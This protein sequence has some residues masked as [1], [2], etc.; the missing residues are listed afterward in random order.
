M[1]A[2]TLVRS[3]FGNGQLSLDTFVGINLFSED[4]AIGIRAERF[5]CFVEFRAFAAIDQG[6]RSRRGKEHDIRIG[7]D[8]SRVVIAKDQR[9]AASLADQSNE[10]FDLGR[11][12]GVHA[13]ERFVEAGK[14]HLRVVK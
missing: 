4:R 10:V 9:D 3:D 14:P 11:E 13:F 12:C 8:L 7:V 6:V 5:A 1:A 2:Q